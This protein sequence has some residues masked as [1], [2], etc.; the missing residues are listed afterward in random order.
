VL[1][2]A[3]V[4]AGL[5][6]WGL[7]PRAQFTVT[8]SGPQVIGN[9]S[10]ELLAADDAVYTLVVAGLGLLAGLGAWLVR[11]HRGLGGLLGV[12]LGM[13]AADLVAWQ[14]GELLGPGPTKAELA[15]TGARVTTALHLAAL[16][17]LAVGVFAAVLVTLIATLVTRSD[18]LGRAPA[19]PATAGPSAGP[20]DRPRAQTDSSPT[21]S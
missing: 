5:L 16:P 9:P 1:A 2:V 19:P 12:A 8:A 3:G 21:G 18:D 15:R 14:V 6:W 17:A 4:L 20:R 10:E 7:A 11:R 13:L